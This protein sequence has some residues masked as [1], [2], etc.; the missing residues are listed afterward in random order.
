[1]PFIEAGD[2]GGHEERNSCPLH[3]P[4][5]RTGKRQRDPPGA[6]QQ[7]AK[8]EVAHEVADFAYVVIPQ[9]EADGINSGEEMKYGIKN[10]TGIR[11]GQKVG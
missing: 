9:H 1:M 6:K 2:Q 11:S 3:R 4:A 10:A 7:D 8:A 5:R